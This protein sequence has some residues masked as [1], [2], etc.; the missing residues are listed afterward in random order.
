MVGRYSIQMTLLDQDCMKDRVKDSLNIDDILV[1][2]VDH[3]HWSSSY[4]CRYSS[5]LEELKVSV[6]REKDRC[7]TYVDE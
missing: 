2:M 4:H 7:L 1:V 5:L 3:F 6:R